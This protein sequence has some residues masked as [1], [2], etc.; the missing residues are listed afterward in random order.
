ME[1]HVIWK[2]FRRWRLH[3][4]RGCRSCVVVAIVLA[5]GSAL[6]SH[7]IEARS[8]DGGSDAFPADASDDGATADASPPFVDPLIP[9]CSAGGGSPR[10]STFGLLL[11]AA[12]LRGAISK[13]SGRS[14]RA[15]RS[16]WRSPSPRATSVRDAALPM[17]STNN[18]DSV[19]IH[20]STKFNGRT[21]VLCRSE[22]P[23]ATRGT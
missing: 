19:L 15:A 1:P 2:R 21:P 20:Y 8:S 16:C 18:L 10:P 4:R 5:V 6:A 14:L 9:A 13:R 17:T 11:L 12:A 7:N 3:G 23:R 22:A